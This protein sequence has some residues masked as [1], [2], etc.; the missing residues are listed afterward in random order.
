MNSTQESNPAAGKYYDHDAAYRKKKRDG[1]IGWDR[2]FDPSEMDLFTRE[3]LLRAG[4]RILNLGCGGGQEAIIAAR[5][6]CHVDAFDASPTA[7]DLAIAN[8]RVEPQAIASRARFTCADFLDHPTIPESLYDVVLDIHC[9]HCM[10]REE[11]RRAFLALS[12]RALRAGAL[13][14]SANMCGLPNTAALRATVKSGSCISLDGRR[15]FAEEPEI[16]ELLAAGGFE[17]VYWNRRRDPTDVDY[18]LFG[19]TKP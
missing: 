17:I 7:I 9:L 18:L 16:R 3:G 15:Y 11:D 2:Q 5:L 4:Q 1:W 19:A 13:L 14:L 10:V 12:G 8:A 6:G